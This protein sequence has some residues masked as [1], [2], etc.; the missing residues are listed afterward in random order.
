MVSIGALALLYE[1][2]LRRSVYREMMKLVGVQRSVINGQLA[3]LGKSRDIAWTKI[4]SDRSLYRVMLADPT[5]WIEQN[6]HLM[7]ESGSRRAIEAEVYLPDPTQPYF[8]DLAVSL[9][10]DPGA[11]KTSVEDAANNLA[12]LWNTES[13]TGRLK[14]KSKI[15]IRWILSRPL[16]SLVLADQR[17]VLLLTGATGRD[18]AESDFAYVYAGDRDQYPSKWFSEQVDRQRNANINFVNEVEQE[19]KGEK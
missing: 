7:L 18:G 3:A 8:G 9:G 17:T 2:S 13:A 11:F 4:L 16:H 5:S 10:R 14:G 1:I 6:F 15:T 12:R 19:P